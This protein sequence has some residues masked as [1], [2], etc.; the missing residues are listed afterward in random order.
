MFV[1]VCVWVW[2]YVY[3]YIYMSIYVY[4]CMYTHTH[5]Y[6]Y[7]F[8]VCVCVCVWVM[9][10]CIY[11]YICIF[12]YVYVCPHTHTY[13][14]ICVCVCVCVCMFLSAYL[15]DSPSIKM[16]QVQ[17][18]NIK[19]NYFSCEKIY[20][21]IIRTS[22]SYTY[23]SEVY[24]FWHKYL[25]KIHFSSRIIK[26]FVLNLSLLSKPLPCSWVRIYTFNFFD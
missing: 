25:L 4:I 14:Y 7:M 1:C 21:Y 23:I 3:I 5:I 13:I 10:V 9:N 16:T 15:S 8:C 20:V 2:M 22:L 19:I 24:L 6:I 17:C 18:I 12:M 26:L 11:I